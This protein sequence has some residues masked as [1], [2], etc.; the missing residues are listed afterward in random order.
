MTDMQFLC[1]HRQKN[2]ACAAFWHRSFLPLS[3]KHPQQQVC[4]CMVRKS[5]PATLVYAGRRPRL[6]TT[7]HLC[8]RP[9]HRFGNDRPPVYTAARF[10][11]RSLLPA[12][13]RNCRERKIS[14][15]NSQT[16]SVR[17]ASLLFAHTAVA[18][19]ANRNRERRKLRRIQLLSKPDQ[20]LSTQIII[21]RRIGRSARAAM[22]AARHLS[23]GTQNRS[24]QQVTSLITDYQYT[25]AK[26]TLTTAK[27]R[28][29]NVTRLR[30][31]NQRIRNQSILCRR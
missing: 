23:S 7:T 6:P 8:A 30:A 31:T 22:A 25:N 17:R 12:L 24:T 19:V 26:T 21:D 18:S 15:R 5:V 3:A 11:C 2:A 10:R 13:V 28:Q 4:R 16:K 29:K 20:R 1:T 27:T 14:A 9:H